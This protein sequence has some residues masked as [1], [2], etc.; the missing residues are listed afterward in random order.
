MTT[1]NRTPAAPIQVQ[2][3]AALSLEQRLAITR[4]GM[5]AAIAHRHGMAVADARAHVAAALDEVDRMVIDDQPQF[6]PH[7]VLAEAR[8]VIEQRG[9]SQGEW[10]GADGAVCAE[11]A[12]ELAAPD[13]AGRQ[14]DAL[15]ELMNRIA[16]DTGEA[17]SVP[18]WN[19]SRRNVG[20]VCRLLY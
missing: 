4:A 15:R 11:R 9:W 18:S 3:L 6:R 17:M 5:N 13:S 12:I 7:P 14:W 8:R 19:D 20:A 1:A 10:T 2:P 16:A